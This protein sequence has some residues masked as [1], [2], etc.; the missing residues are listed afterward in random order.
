MC[1]C[2]CVCV[3]VSV[4]VS[5]CFVRACV[6]LCVCVCVCVYIGSDHGVYGSAV[7]VN[8]DPELSQAFGVCVCARVRV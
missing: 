5:V 7:S 1:V 3:S 4:S 2:V 8:V 6:I